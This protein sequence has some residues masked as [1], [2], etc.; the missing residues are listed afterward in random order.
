MGAIRLVSI[1]R[2]KVGKPP[3][4]SVRPDLDQWLLSTRQWSCARLEQAISGSGRSA[5]PGADGNCAHVGRRLP[6]GCVAGRHHAAEKLANRP[7]H[8]LV[9]QLKAW[10][11]EDAVDV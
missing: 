10:I 7:A 6:H 3:M 4:P 11:A 9:K 2:R 1:S 8:A 5:P